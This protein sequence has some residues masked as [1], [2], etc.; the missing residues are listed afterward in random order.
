[1]CEL[2][3]NTGICVVIPMLGCFTTQKYK[4]TQCALLQLCVI[5]MGKYAEC[6]HCNY[7]Q[8]QLKLSGCWCRF[9]LG[10]RSQKSKS[11]PLSSLSSSY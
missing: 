11:L 8:Q 1:M 4:L 10:L 5:I 3:Q 9:L 7:R 6:N 2:M